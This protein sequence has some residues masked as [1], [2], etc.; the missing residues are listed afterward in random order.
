MVSSS[1]NKSIDILP[2]L[3]VEAEE[4]SWGPTVYMAPLFSSLTLMLEEPIICHSNRL[5][6][7]ERED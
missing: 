7:R 1:V 5:R 4:R 2:I 6:V 3:R